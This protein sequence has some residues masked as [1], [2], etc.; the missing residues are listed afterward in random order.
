MRICKWETAFCV[1]VGELG[2]HDQ[3][4]RRIR[5]DSSINLGFH[6]ELR[7]LVHSALL[8]SV[9]TSKRCELG[10]RNCGIL[11]ARNLSDELFNKNLQRTDDCSFRWTLL[12][13][14]PHCQTLE[15]TSHTHNS[16]CTGV[17][18]LEGKQSSKEG[19]ALPCLVAS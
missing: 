3:P 5:K 15:R 16:K 11:Y 6:V 13:R 8:C 14:A 1:L 12:G 7:V 9:L 17:P 4:L 19:R 18:A 2:V 10:G